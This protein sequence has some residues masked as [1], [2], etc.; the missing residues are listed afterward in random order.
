[1]GII[2]PTSSTILDTYATVA[3]AVKMSVAS[4]MMAGGVYAK[5]T[6]GGLVGGPPPGASPPA[7]PAPTAK[8]CR[9][10]ILRRRRCFWLT[11]T[12]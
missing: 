7:S 10:S 6:G 11:Y 5:D 8:P 3:K 1:V 12:L 9:H 4:P 2:N